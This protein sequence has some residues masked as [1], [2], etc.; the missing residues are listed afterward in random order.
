MFMIKSTKTKGLLPSLSLNSRFKST[1]DDKDT[2]DARPSR[3][4]TRLGSTGTNH[5]G[6][7][8]ASSLHMTSDYNENSANQ[9]SGAAA[10]T[11]YLREAARQLD[12]EIPDGIPLKVC[13]L[14]C[15]TGG[16]SISPIEAILAVINRPLLVVLNDLP[17]N[18]WEVLKR[19]VETAFPSVTFEYKPMSMYSTD[20]DEDVGTVHITYSVFAQ[21][22]L[23]R[24][25]P[26]KSLPEGALWANQLPNGHPFRKIWE[27]ASQVDWELLLKKQST[28]VAPGG[29]FILHIQGATNAGGLSEIGASTLQRAKAIMASKGELGSDIVVPEY[30]KNPAEVVA[31]LCSGQLGKAWNIKEMKYC[32]LPCEYKREFEQQ[33]PELQ[34]QPSAGKRTVEKQIG[35][36]KAF[37]DSSL[38]EAADEDKIEAY[39]ALVESLANGDPTC[40][41]M[42]WMAH[43]LVLK[44]SS[45]APIAPIVPSDESLSRSFRAA[46]S[47]LSRRVHISK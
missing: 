12:R 22:W 8:G 2:K 15:A 4:S 42:N 1:R 3:W 44:R 18:D 13:E 7:L 26:T 16:S 36:L 9:A 46:T 5:S 41:A 6:A 47:A 17:E 31:P 40:L 29:Y 21:H 25:A 43:F 38:I 37:M 19:T 39:W 33:P 28:L 45:S 34:L 27:K 24:G 35:F 20:N 30:L 10:L 23:S 11:K 14:G 32:E